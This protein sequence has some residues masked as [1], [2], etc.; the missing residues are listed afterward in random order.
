MLE[1]ADIFRRYSPTYLARFGNAMLPS[2]KRVITD[3]CQC[4]TR[5]LGGY[6]RKP[7]RCDYKAHSRQS[8]GSRHCPAC[9]S[10]H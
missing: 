1:V 9:F 4:R 6:A 10:E 7:N 5:D 3:I 2:H 8:C